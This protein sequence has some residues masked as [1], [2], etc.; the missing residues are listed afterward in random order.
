MASSRRHSQERDVFA[1]L[2]CTCGR[3]KSR[4][5][6][7]IGHRSCI[8]SKHAKQLNGL[9]PHARRIDSTVVLDVSDYYVILTL[10]IWSSKTG[11][12]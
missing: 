9:S 10:T 1:P 4:G 12:L 2:E 7:K 8:F 3:P 11:Q 5:R 6:L